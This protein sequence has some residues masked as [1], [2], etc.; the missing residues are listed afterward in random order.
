VRA[1]CGLVIEVEGNIGSGKSTLTDALR[2]VVNESDE[3]KPCV[4]H[5][6]KVNAR[7]LA[8]YYGDMKRYAFAFQAYMLTTRSPPVPPLVR[9]HTHIHTRARGRARVRAHGPDV[10]APFFLGSIAFVT[11]VM[12]RSR[13]YQLE[14]SVRQAKAGSMVFLDRGAVGDTLFA[15]QNVTVSIL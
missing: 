1:L 4:V 10:M 12:L 11:F 5:G 15:I 6:E 9:T 8:T 3:R 7:F 2:R 13:V 14:E